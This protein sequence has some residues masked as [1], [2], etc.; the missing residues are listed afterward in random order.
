MIQY[1]YPEELQ[2]ALIFA[3]YLNDLQSKEIFKRGEISSKN[4][5]IYISKFFWKIVTLSA[6]KSITL[7]FEGSTEYWTE[8]LY[9]SLG[10]YMIRAGYGEEWN[11]EVDNA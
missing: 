7:P 5:A 8:K 3:D 4:E 9:N 6:E 1:K 2:V 10:G 11:E